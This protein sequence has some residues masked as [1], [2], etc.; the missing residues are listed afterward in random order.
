[1][2]RRYGSL[3]GSVWLRA[4]PGFLERAQPQRVDVMPKVRLV[5]HRETVGCFEPPPTAF[6]PPQIQPILHLSNRKCSRC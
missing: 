4:R 1:M 2:G 3:T 6:V 5:P